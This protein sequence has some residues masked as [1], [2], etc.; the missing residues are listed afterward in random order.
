MHD[1]RLVV[2]ALRVVPR[3][4]TSHPDYLWLNRLQCLGIGQA[5]L[6]RGESAT[7]STQC[8]KHRWRTAFSRGPVD[9]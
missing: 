6:E 8:G 9:W 5:F 4:Q 2:P 3:Y 1:H 7:T